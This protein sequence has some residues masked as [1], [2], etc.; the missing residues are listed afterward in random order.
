MADEFPAEITQFIGQNI[1]SVAQLEALVL[2]WQDRDRAWQ[3]DEI[4]K[5]L[6]IPPDMAGEL[7]TN[8]ARRGILQIAPP[9][10]V[11]Y[12]YQPADVEMDNLIGRL[13]ALYRERRV[14]VISL[15][16]SRPL[17]KVQTFADAF[18]LRKESTS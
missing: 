14:A 12:V 3:A 9:S 15:I 17:N 5:S 1:E 16:Y 10:E 4:A 8:F 2:L 6:Y 7:L 13:A 11:H 18:R